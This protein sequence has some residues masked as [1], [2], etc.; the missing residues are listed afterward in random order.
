MEIDKA[1]SKDLKRKNRDAFGYGKGEDVSDESDDD[2]ER[3]GRNNNA[4]NKRK[5]NY[6][7]PTVKNSD[8]GKL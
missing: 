5:T 7:G 8:L 1:K 3:N 2:D 4:G 6:D